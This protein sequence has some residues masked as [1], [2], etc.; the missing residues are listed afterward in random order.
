[1]SER[2]VL[3]QVVR[4]MP[5]HSLEHITGYFNYKPQL[6]VYVFQLEVLKLYPYRKR[7]GL[8]S[9]NIINM[10]YPCHRRFLIRDQHTS[11]TTGRRPL[12]QHLAQVSA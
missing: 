9:I 10:L 6:I 4:H 1:M 5:A 7:G 3:L 8:L 11:S 2:R 12:E